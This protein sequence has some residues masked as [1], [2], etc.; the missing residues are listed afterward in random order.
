MLNR[1]E[2]PAGD[3]GAGGG[4]VCFGTQH[5]GGHAG[6]LGG[7]LQ[8][9]AGGEGHIR[10]FPDDGGYPPAAQ[11]FF[12]CP[13]RIRVTSGADQDHVRRIDPELQQ[14]R[15]VQRAGIERPGPLAPED[16]VVL[17]IVRQTAR[18]QGT[19][20]RGN[21]G[22]RGK[23]FVQRALYQPTAGQMIVYSF[24]TEGQHWLIGP[25]QRAAK[26][27][28]LTDLRLQLFQTGWV[29]DRV[30]GWMPD[31][32][33]GREIGREISPN[34]AVSPFLRGKR[35]VPGASGGPRHRLFQCCVRIYVLVLF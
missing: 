9:A 32:R 24:H 33:A 11:P 19:E 29:A 2:L 17:R 22:I 28:E 35:A 15:A 13:E 18:Q 8:P 1:V 5:Q 12:H 6:F 31:V 20:C 10:Y 25:G 7:K 23:Y 30:T 4:P 21:T 16:R 26:S 34:P 14:G 27:F 3:R